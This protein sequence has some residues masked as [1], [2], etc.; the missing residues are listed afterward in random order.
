MYNIKD[1]LLLQLT[2]SST[3]LDS[4]M[5]HKTTMSNNLVSKAIHEM[6]FNEL[7]LM[8]D[9]AFFKLSFIKILLGILNWCSLFGFANENMYV[10]LYLLKISYRLSSCLQSL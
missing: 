4:Y 8:H 10:G 5:Q 1:R 9:Y 2:C 7:Y 3:K 6:V